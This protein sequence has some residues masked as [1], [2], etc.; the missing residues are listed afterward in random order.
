MPIRVIYS[1]EEIFRGISLVAN[2]VG[3]TYGPHGR[4]VALERAGGPL[5]TKDG[6]TIAWELKPSHPIRSAGVKIVQQALDK[7]SKVVGD[8]TTT[9][10]LL[11]EGL[12]RQARKELAGGEDPWRI[13]QRLRSYSWGDILAGY[14]VE[15]LESDL[16][17]IALSASHEDVPLAKALVEAVLQVGSQGLVIVEEGTSRKVEILHKSGFVLDHGWESLEMASPEGGSRL[18][19]GPLVALVD[20]ELTKMEDVAS[21]LEEATAFPHPV[22]IVCRG[23]YGKALATLLAN[24]RKLARDVGPTLEV[25]ATRLSPQDRHSWFLDLQALTGGTVVQNFRRFDPA[26]FGGLRSATLERDRTILMAAEDAT[27]RLELRMGGVQTELERA[28]TTW[29]QEECKRRLAMLTGGL[30]CLRVGGNTPAEIK[31]RRGRTEDALRAVQAATEGIVPLDVWAH[32]ASETGEPGLWAPL[33]CS[34]RNAGL[35]RHVVYAQV[36]AVGMTFDVRLGIWTQTF[37]KGLVI[38]AKQAKIILEVACSV[39]SELILSTLV[40]RRIRK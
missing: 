26:W 8:G 10:A 23:I 29:D 34:L 12:L 18:L 17:A 30:C 4:A 32:L 15:A 19:E 21:I 11:I 38:P 28:P 36:P 20:R 1:P 25:A 7:V 33:D 40:I 2:T 22:L 37:S 3:V 24:D 9:T 13:A 14:T 39:V 16:E 35:S 31:E 5:W 27:P 6:A